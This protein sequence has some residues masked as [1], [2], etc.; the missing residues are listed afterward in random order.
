[1]RLALRAAAAFKQ[2]CERHSKGDGRN[3]KIGP[4]P[5]LMSHQKRGK[6]RKQRGNRSLYFDVQIRICPNRNY[7]KAIENM[8]LSTL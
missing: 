4:I 3:F 2:V 5:I 6:C 7:D 8:K 1:M